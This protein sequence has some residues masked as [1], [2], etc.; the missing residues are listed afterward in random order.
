MPRSSLLSF[1]VLLA[2]AFACGDDERR[3]DVGP[4]DGGARDGGSAADG[5]AGDAGLREDA[6]SV[7]DGGSVDDAGA[8]G[9]ASIDATVTLGEVAVYGDC[10]PIVPADP[11][12]AFWTATVAGASGATATLTDAELFI[13]TETQTL[14]V[15]EPIVSLSGGAG[16]QEQ[17]KTSGD[18]AIAGACASLCTDASYTLEL[19]YAID[20]ASVVV[21]DTGAFDCVY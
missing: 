4:S 18:P 13:A 20:G 15:D 11:V 14:T 2:C 5:A 1:L 21:S 12:V 7:E 6:G 9:D 3:A 16:S 19:T 8:S 17:R 10:M